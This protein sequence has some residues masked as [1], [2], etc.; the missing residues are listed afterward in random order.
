MDANEINIRCN[1]LESFLVASDGQFLGKL[2]LNT[3]DTESILN[4]FGQYGSQFSATSIYNQF[5]MYGSQYSSLSQFNPY[6][7]TPPTIYLKGNKFGF[8][9]VNKF[10]FGTLEPQQLRNW[11]Q[12]NG[13]YY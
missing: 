10:L 5:S 9:S 3:F 2:C 12:F 1:K 8:L 13:L 7:L 4:K 11:M 6:T